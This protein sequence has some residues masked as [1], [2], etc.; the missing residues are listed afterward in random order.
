MLV[1]EHQASQDVALL[2]EHLYPFSACPASRVP[3][4]LPGGQWLLGSVGCRMKPILMQ[5]TQSLMAISSKKF[6]L[7]VGGGYG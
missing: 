3:A 2:L 4:G 7:C 1:C 6:F 5:L